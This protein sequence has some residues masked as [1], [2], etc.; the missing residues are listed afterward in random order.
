MSSIGS[1]SSHQQQQK[2]KPNGISTVLPELDFA[3]P[4]NSMGLSR[5]GVTDTGKKWL[6]ASS[7]S[8][9]FGGGA[10]TSFIGDIIM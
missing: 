6:L 2:K 3:M 4:K 10:E 5:N 1:F 8:L 9:K 7:Q